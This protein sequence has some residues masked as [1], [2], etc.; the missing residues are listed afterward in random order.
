MSARRILVVGNFLS[1]GTHRMYCEDMAE[2]M[3]ARHWGVV[4]TSNQPKRVRRL[5]DM[6]H[7]AWARRSDYDVAHVDV[8][9]GPSFLWAE[10]VC[11]EL[12]WLSKPYVLTLRGGNLPEFSRRWP[13]RTR[14]LLRSAA[15]ITSPSRYLKEAMAALA[16]DIVE[17]P[18]A[19]DLTRYPF[20]LR[21]RPNPRLVW[22]RAFHA[23][24]NPVMAVEVLARVRAAFP[25]AT[26][27]MIGA[28]RGDGSRAAVQRRAN[29]LGVRDHLQLV[30]GV[31]KSEVARYLAAGDVFLNTTDAD[32]T[33]VSV[34][35]AMACGLC[36]VS[37][38]VG[39]IPYLLTH[40]HDA[41]LVPSRDPDA[42]ANAIARLLREPELSARL[43]STGHTHAGSRN[44]PHVI[45]RWEDLFAR[46]IAN[47]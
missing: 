4:R 2:R 39:G 46:V 22:L 7:T 17:L 43:S 40:E 18:N 19:L 42:M 45:E 41:L 9:S 34:L 29:E 11:F 21:A 36:V 31:P 13:H 10:M 1:A 5:A 30:D 47:A 3:E 8:F 20:A 16:G 27:V 24:Y 28:D 33:P 35:E 15:A 37:T 32:N 38:N 25:H 14:A 12:R 23:V 44:W 6:L 26:L